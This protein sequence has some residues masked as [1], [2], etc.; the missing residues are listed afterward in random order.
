MGILMAF[1]PFFAFA[2]VEVLAGLIP[3]LVAGTAVSAALIGRDIINQRSAKILEIGTAI[4]FLGLTLLALVSESS[5]SLMGVRLRVD[6]GLLLVVLTSIAIRKPFTLQYTE[7]G[8]GPQDANKPSV[9]KA[10]Y[11]ITAVWAAA[12]AVMVVADLI[13]IYAPQLPHVIGIGITVAALW[14]AA[15]FTAWFPGRLRTPSAA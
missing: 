4:L 12:F 7:N 13:L 10:N 6:A 1:A 14:S 9:L 2:A 3:G 5:W 11:T 15:R 8:S